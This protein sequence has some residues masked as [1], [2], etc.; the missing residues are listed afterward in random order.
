MG[1]TEKSEKNTPM[2]EQYRTMKERYPNYI[3]F[4]RLGDFFEMFDRDAEEVSKELELTLTSR[5]GVP[6][7]GVPH[8]SAL[9]YIKRLI[10]NGHRVAVCEQTEDPALAKGLVRREVVRVISPGTVVDEGMLDEG[11]NNYILC[12]LY[13]G[14]ECGMVFADVSTGEIHLVQ[15]AGKDVSELTKGIIGELD[16]YMPVEILFNE[17]FLDLDQVHIYITDK[18]YRCIADVLP[19]EKYDP[20]NTEALDRQFV[21]EGTI[22]ENMG[23][24]KKALY[25]LY[26]YINENYKDDTARTVKLIVHGGSDYM[27]L[28]LSARRNLELTETMRG[29][30]YRGSLLWVLDKTRTGLGKRRL[31]QVITQPLMKPMKILERLDAVEELSSDMAGLEELRDSLEGIYDLE[32]LMSRIAYKLASPRDVS[33]LGKACANLPGVKK[34]LEGYKSSLIKRLSENI[35]AH[36][37]ISDLVERALADELPINTRD[38]GYIRSGFN[39][40]LD[41][42]RSITGGGRELLE[43]IEAREK[44]AT[45][46]KTLKV[47]F[48]RVFGYY[49][50]VSKGQ[51][52]QVPDRYVRKQTLTN[53]ERYITEEL[54]DIERDMLTAGERIIKLEAKLF[55][56]VRKFIA[57]RMEQVM[58]TAEAVADIDVLACFARVSLENNYVKPEITLDSIIDIKGGRHPVVE[59]ILPDNPFTPNDTYLDLKQ[60]RLLIITGPNM[61]GKSTYMRQVALITLMAQMGC[62]VPAARARIGVVDKVYTRVGAS[63]DLSSGK[64]TFMVEMDEVAEILTGATKQSLVIMDEIGRGTS[65]FDGISIAK[66]VAE[67]INGKNIGCRTLFATHYHE[68]TALEDSSEGIRNFSVAVVKKGDDIKFLHKI[69]EGGADDSYG[70]EVAKLAGLP[71]KVIE[72]ARTALSDMERESKIDLENKLRQEKNAK[73][74]IDFSEIN[75]NEVIQRLKNLDL[76]DLTPKEAWQVLEEMKALV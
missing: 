22:P 51:I 52:G 3:L 1:K 13:D 17:K 30:E 48:N 37:D 65:T 45:G 40:E 33:A 61:A 62:F 56:E 66:A 15:K 49:I 6:M 11:R 26:N 14:K 32:R 7:C 54:K 21:A 29:R 24:C 64:S 18:L 35:S 50:E 8:H 25:A 74:Q 36:E 71:K 75:K 70:I 59:K 60:N 34:A 44:E 20:D 57:E 67:Y 31:K 16:G 28:N 4:F 63:D 5:A 73:S 46:I 39:E 43:K 42:L 9:S 12:L 72:A 53:G 41:K 69:V 2:L 76:D 10:E 27:E 55:A 68:L 23:L 47:G 19:D 58:N 38:G